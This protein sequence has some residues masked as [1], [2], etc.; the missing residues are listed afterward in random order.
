MDH[1]VPAIGVPDLKIL[2]AV[3]VIPRPLILTNGSTMTTLTVQRMLIRQNPVSLP[4]HAV[5]SM[6]AIRSCHNVVK[7]PIRTLPWQ[8]LTLDQLKNSQIAVN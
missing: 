2:L 1:F 8:S 4:G 7:E 5:S 6:Q 3:L